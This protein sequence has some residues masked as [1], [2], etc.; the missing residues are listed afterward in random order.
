MSHPGAC[1]DCTFMIRLY[2]LTKNKSL[3]SNEIIYDPSDIYV[4][5]KISLDS[6][7]EIHR[8]VNSLIKEIWK[9]DTFR[10]WGFH[11]QMMFNEKSAPWLHCHHSYVYCPFA[12]D[13]SITAS[14]SGKP[15]KPSPLLGPTSPLGNPHRA[16]QIESIPP[17]WVCQPCCPENLGTLFTREATNSRAKGVEK[18]KGEIYFRCRQL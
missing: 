17:C 7:M 4:D 9:M 14:N 8:N 16:G 3:P 12:T 18:R 5:Q 13:T 2:S 15:E 6:L 1:R 11:G 10:M